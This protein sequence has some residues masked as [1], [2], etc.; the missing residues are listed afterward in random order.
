M[1]F[2]IVQ[3]GLHDGAEHFYNQT[4]GW[5]AAC[6][7]RG[8]TVRLLIHAAASGSAAALKGQAR[9]RRAPWVQTQSTRPWSAN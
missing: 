8:I 7:A 9:E 4:L 2:V 6:A 3:S 1:R 5:R